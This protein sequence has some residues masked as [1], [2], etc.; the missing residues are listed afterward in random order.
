M[1]HAILKHKQVHVPNMGNSQ[2]P[3]KALQDTFLSTSSKGT[4][5]VALAQEA[6]SSATWDASGTVP[7]R[8]LTYAYA[9]HRGTKT[10]L[11]QD[12]LLIR[13]AFL[14]R[15]EL[16]LFGIFDGHGSEGAKLS[17]VIRDHV[18]T[19]LGRQLKGL[20]NR[21]P[22]LCADDPVVAEGIVNALSSAFIVA[23]QASS[24][25]GT[26]WPARCIPPYSMATCLW[27]KYDVPTRNSFCALG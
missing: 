18:E 26:E 8:V 22:N 25:V 7:P 1:S 11:N 24:H 20:M 21:F 16:A 4:L 27:D 23:H 15:P 6:Q 5:K 9:S 2:S 3:L 14:D 13:P 17:T 12:C 10:P 19:A